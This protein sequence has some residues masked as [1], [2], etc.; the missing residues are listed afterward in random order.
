MLFC[1]LPKSPYPHSTATSWTP[2]GKAWRARPIS[3][4]IEAPSVPTRS[5]RCSARRRSVRYGGE[6]G[7]EEEEEDNY[8]H[9]E[10]IA[11]LELYSRAA[12]GEALIIHANVDGDRVEVLIFKVRFKISSIPLCYM[13]SFEEDF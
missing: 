11:K 12:R 5:A 2:A 6:D 9:N 1:L 10:E 13:I 8:G 3:A 4:N 7:D